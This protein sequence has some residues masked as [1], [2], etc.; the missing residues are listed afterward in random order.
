MG[1]IEEARGG[2][3]FLD[4][5][6]EMHIDLQSKL[7]RVLETSQFFKVGATIPTTADVRI[8]SATHRNLPNEVAEGRFRED[9]YYRLNVFTIQIPPLRERRKDI[10]LLAQYFIR[11]FATKMNKAIEGMSKEFL[12]VL[13]RQTWKGNIRELR[14]V[15]ERAVILEEGPE[16]SAES[17]PME[18]WPDNEIRPDISVFDL[19]TMEKLHIRKVLDHTRGNKVEAARLL[20]IGLTTVYRKMEEYGLN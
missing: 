4:E 13:E 7:L 15:I 20:N 12:D 1:L 8:I 10:P 2:T 9:L 17:L 14:N 11:L 3:L 18:M 16:L 6:G 19:A 5:I